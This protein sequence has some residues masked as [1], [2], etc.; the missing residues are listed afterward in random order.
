MERQQAT[1]RLRTFR[2]RC[3]ATNMRVDAL[4]RLVQPKECALVALHHEI[5]DM[6]SSS[7]MSCEGLTKFDFRYGAPT[8]CE[9]VL[10]MFMG[11]L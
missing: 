3:V 1:E 11:R 9:L 4:G 6:Q 8:T 2:I 5:R 10:N 7:K